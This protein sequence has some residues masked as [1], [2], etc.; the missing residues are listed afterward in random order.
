MQHPAFE[1]YAGSAEAVRAACAADRLDV[2]R[3]RKVTPIF[4]LFPEP[5][6]ASDILLVERAVAAISGRSEPSENAV[7]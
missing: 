5:F 2:L 4:A 6:T 3:P 7:E 1:I